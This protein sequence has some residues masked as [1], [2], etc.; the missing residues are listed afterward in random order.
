MKPLRA[1]HGKSSQH[2]W[3][4][5]VIRAILTGLYAALAFRKV[6]EFTQPH[7]N[8]C[9]KEPVATPDHVEESALS[10]LVESQAKEKLRAVTRM[11]LPRQHVDTTTLEQVCAAK[12]NVNSE[13]QVS[14]GSASCPPPPASQATS[15]AHE[16]PRMQV[17]TFTSQL[18]VFY[19]SQVEKRD[20]KVLWKDF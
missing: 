10:V 12:C 17:S 14:H 3:N 4:P 18:Q 15:A 5:L 1:I 9:L 16:K 7:G 6:G 13:P 11:W 20:Q 8:L 19:E 2:C